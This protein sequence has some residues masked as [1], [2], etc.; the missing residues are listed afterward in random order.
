MANKIPRVAVREQE[1]KVRAHNF[2]EVSYGY[3]KQEAM[4]EASRCLHC[5]NPRCV[6]GCPVSIQIPEF[7]ARVAEG[8]IAAAAGVIAQDSLLPAV[9]GRVCPQ[10]TQCEGQCILGVKGDL[11]RGSSRD[12]NRCRDRRALRSL[13]SQTYSLSDLWR[14]FSRCVD[15][16]TRMDG[17]SLCGAPSA[18]GN[19]GMR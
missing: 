6:G 9:C 18:R 4:L 10:E 19:H 12:K 15:E 7:I 11:C 8:D 17:S 5:K 16:S 1:P 14:C 3:D 13:F 2:E